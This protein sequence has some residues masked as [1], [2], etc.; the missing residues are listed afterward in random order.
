MYH[1]TNCLSTINSNTIILGLSLLGILIL[2]LILSS[3][4]LT[5]IFKDRFAESK[6]YKFNNKVLASFIVIIFILILITKSCT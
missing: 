6:V 5:L 1:L 2:Y 3:I 4:F